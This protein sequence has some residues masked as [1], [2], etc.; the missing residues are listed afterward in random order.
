MAEKNK[1]EPRRKSDAPANP[2][3]PDSPNP[4]GEI[5]QGPSK[6]EQF[7]ENNQKM[8]MIVCLL[9]VVGVSGWIIVKGMREAKETSAG[10]ALVASQDMGDFRNVIEQFAGTVAAGT[11]Q[12]QL[13]RAQWEDGLYADSITTLRDFIDNNP[14]H[15]IEPTARM[16]L[17]SYLLEDGESEEALSLLKALADDGK[18]AHIAPM[19]LIRIGDY[20][21]ALGNEN[22]ARKAYERAADPEAKN[23]PLTSRLATSRL[24]MLGVQLPT[25]VE[26]P[27]PPPPKIFPPLLPTDA[28]DN[29]APAPV[30]IPPD[31][32]PPSGP[33]PAPAPAPTPAP[34]PSPAPA[35]EPAPGTP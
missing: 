30:P 4:L 14:D 7:L 13:A 20:E 10:E 35:P 11:A 19:A 16:L 5:E 17:S 32:I 21:S 29:T 15:A 18:A 2:E 31:S 24:D 1:S 8:L 34:E 3:G 12:V 22:A 6:F 9:V 23:S 26:R 28:P 33:G 27:K 25:T